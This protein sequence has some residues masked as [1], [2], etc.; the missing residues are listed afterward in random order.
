MEVKDLEKQINEKFADLKEQVETKTSG[1]KADEFKELEQKHAD[2][3]NQ[4]KESDQSESIE[5]MQKHLDKLDVK[6]QKK[7]AQKLEGMSKQSFFDQL[8]NTLKG[9]KEQLSEMK[10]GK[11]SSVKLETKEVADLDFDETTHN[12]TANSYATQTTERRGLRESAYSPLWLRNFLPANSTDGSTIQYLKEDG[13]NGAVGVWDGTGSIDTLS[14]KPGVSPKFDFETENVEW[15]A[16][17]TRV[18][19]EMLDDISWLR[20]YLSR[21]LMTGKTGLYV[22]ENTQILNKLTAGA[23]STSYD[24]DNTTLLEAVYDAAFGQLLDNYNYPTHIFVNN[25]DMVNLIALNKAE[26][27]GEYDLPPNTV[28]VVNGQMTIGGIPVI[29]TPQVDKG[30]L[31]VIDANQTEFITRMSPEIRFFEQDRDNVPKN[32]ITVRVEERV[33]PIVYDST[34]VIYGEPAVPA[35]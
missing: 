3:L 26:G 20:G 34:A 12:F 30:K 17:I 35:G 23:N 21:K 2:L 27:S 1:V 24:G 13:W 11:T 22:A 10:N 18:K 25:R 19:R 4:I 15:I 32:L 31:L 16:G 6:M 33:L 7:T 9:A 29:G 14:E 8:G 28:V 5:E